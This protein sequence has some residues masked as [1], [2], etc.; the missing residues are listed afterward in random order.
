M[1]QR[2]QTHSVSAS[3]CGQVQRSQNITAVSKPVSNTHNSFTAEN[4]TWTD[5]RPRTGANTF[6]TQLNHEREKSSSGME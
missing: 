2:E 3:L 5:G 6:T 4:V 1:G